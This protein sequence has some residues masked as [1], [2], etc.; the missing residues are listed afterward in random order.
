LRRLGGLAAGASLLLLAAC[1][2][3]GS[4]GGSGAVVV[5]GSNVAPITVDGGPAGTVNYPFVTVTVC[6]PGTTTCTTVDHVQLDTGSTGLRLVSS[7]LPSGFTL[8][9]LAAANGDPVYECLSF[10]DGYSWGSVRQADVKL[11]DGTAS[12]IS[13]HLVGDATVPVGYS[14]AP[15]VPANCP[16]GGLN[17]LEVTVDAFG[18]NGILGVSS[19]KDD[20]GLNCE[21]GLA[22]NAYYDCSSSACT[23]VAV[24]QANQ[25]VNPVYHFASNNNGIIIE[26][27]ALPS[28]GQ[29]VTRG[30]LVL[31]IDTQSNNAL[32]TRSQLTLDPNSPVGAVF[33][34]V[35][36]P[37]N[38]QADVPMPYS[39]VDTGS[40]ATFFSDSTI[41]SCTSNP[42]FYCPKT[43]TPL[44]LT[45]TNTGLNGSSSSVAFKVVN[46]D[47]I[48]AANS[49][50]TALPNIAGPNV[51]P[52]S[53]DWGMPFFYGRSVYIGFD[54]R[55]GS[56]GIPGPYVAY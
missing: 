25:V 36:H 20:C 14:A 16:N 5:T 28:T 13:I 50:F 12:N 41:P 11:A 49:K 33:S 21:N 45:A 46:A 4:A 56:N 53:F 9:Q 52:K 18:A 40:N 35:Y 31:G 43:A 2:G 48:T 47:A 1:G 3:G 22:T 44:D 19:Y 39:F 42:G 23:S 7:A 24:L 10:A 32:G 37:G 27:P 54:G 55:S 15:A 38:G 26:M 29:L 30:S 6:V 17:G 51:L 34:T 8:P